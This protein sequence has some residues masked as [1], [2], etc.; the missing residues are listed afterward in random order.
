M[1]CTQWYIFNA[2]T[3]MCKHRF[4]ASTPNY[5]P[6]C[7]SL[8]RGHLLLLDS[9]SSLRRRSGNVHRRR[10]RVGPRTHMSVF[11]VERLSQMLGTA[12]HRPTD[13]TSAATTAARTQMSWM[14]VM[15]V[16]MARMGCR[17]YYLALPT[18]RK[19]TPSLCSSHAPST[20]CNTS[21]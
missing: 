5:P 12:Y 8:I 1:T 7:E 21:L 17:T 13:G 18:K 16:S 4:H 20:Y 2:R 11:L 15:T 19:S 9:G 14:P 6:G 10:H 3:R